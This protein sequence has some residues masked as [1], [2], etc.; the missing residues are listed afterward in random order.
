MGKEA[1]EIKHEL[2]FDITLKGEKTRIESKSTP[3]S[4]LGT[5]LEVVVSIAQNA[6]KSSGGNVSASEFLTTAATMCMLDVETETFKK[7]LEAF[8]ELKKEVK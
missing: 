7:H 8:D 1:K 4:D 6:H 2:S 3:G 5:I